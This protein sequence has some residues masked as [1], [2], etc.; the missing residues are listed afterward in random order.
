MTAL[1]FVNHFPIFS[2]NNLAG[3]SSEDRNCFD[4]QQPQNGNSFLQDHLK[5]KQSQVSK[6][7]FFSDHSALTNRSDTKMQFSLILLKIWA[8][9]S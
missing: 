9:K 2:L 1:I 3:K 6:G 5:S 8:L 7:Q 4:T